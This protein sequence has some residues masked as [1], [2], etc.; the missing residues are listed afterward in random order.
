MGQI[1]VSVAGISLRDAWSNPV[2]HLVSVETLKNYPSGENSVHCMG[3]V[4]AFADGCRLLHQR[5][6]EAL[7][8]QWRAV[9]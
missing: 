8:L 1:D 2:M 7:P 3:S 4:R 6:R 9:H 5:K